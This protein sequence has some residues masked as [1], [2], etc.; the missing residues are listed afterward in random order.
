MRKEDSLTHGTVREAPRGD[1]RLRPIT[2]PKSLFWALLTRHPGTVISERHCDRK[3][4]RKQF[5]KGLG[6]GG[7]WET[8]VSIRVG[9]DSPGAGCG[10]W[11]REAEEPRVPVRAPVWRI[12]VLR[13][14]PAGG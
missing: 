5:W 6:G 2:S 1:G 13:L 14:L 8:A 7:C 3:T 11:A 10:P 4:S 9:Q 12:N